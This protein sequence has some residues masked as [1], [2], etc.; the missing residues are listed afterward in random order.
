MAQEVKCVVE[1]LAQHS[2]AQVIAWREHEMLEIERAAAELRGS[3]ACEEW[4]RGCDDGMRAQV[5]GL[6]CH[7]VGLG[8]SRR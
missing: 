1:W 2:A 5:A 7:G 8:L 4:L 3:G 6:V